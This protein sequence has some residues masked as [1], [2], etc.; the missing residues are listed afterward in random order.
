MSYQ[1]FHGVMIAA[2]K[3]FRLTPEEIVGRSRV[4]AIVRSR[5]AVMY[6]LTQR[7]DWDLGLI[8][9]L[10]SRDHTTVL[11]ARDVTAQRVQTDRLLAQRV[12]ALMAA[13]E[14]S[15]AEYDLWLDSLKGSSKPVPRPLVLK[16]VA[17]GIPA[18]PKEMGH[19]APSR[20]KWFS[21]IDED[22]HC[23]GERYMQHDMRRGSEML[24]EAIARARA[25]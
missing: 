21:S 3:V 24:C 10:F 16:P 13:E 25:A 9:R 1:I 2:H 8:G 23:Y 22:G 19:I 6:V 11:H 17:R 4:K 12:A 20:L 5:Q 7:T 14:V 18:P 15:M